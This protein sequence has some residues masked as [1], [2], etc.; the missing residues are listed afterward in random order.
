MTGRDLWNLRYLDR[1]TKDTFRSVWMVSLDTWNGEFR[2]FQK[3][4]DGDV[5]I[6]FTLE[7]FTEPTVP[8]R[9]SM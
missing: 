5:W 7:R 8:V 9:K 3:I 2:I 1:R 6:L 4:I